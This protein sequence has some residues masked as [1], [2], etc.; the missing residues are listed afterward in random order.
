MTD[1]LEIPK[2]IA[3]QRQLFRHDLKQSIDNKFG[4]RHRII[5]FD[6]FNLEYVT[7]S[8]IWQISTHIRYRYLQSDYGVSSLSL[9]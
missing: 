6:D 7:L 4:K 9:Q 1:N 2:Y 3:Y 5:V 8:E